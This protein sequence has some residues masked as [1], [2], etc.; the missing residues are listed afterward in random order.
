MEWP[1]EWS[2]R[3]PEWRAEVLQE[4]HQDHNARLEQRDL[5]DRG[6]P[7]DRGVVYVMELAE[8]ADSSATG[9]ATADL[10]RIG[11][12][13]DDAR[14]RL[15]VEVLRVGLRASSMSRTRITCRPARAGRQRPAELD[16]PGTAGPSAPGGRPTDASA[17]GW[18]HILRHQAEYSS[19]G[20]D[21]AFERAV[22]TLPTPGRR[23][24]SLMV[25]V[26]AVRCPASSVRH[27]LS[28]PSTPADCAGSERRPWRLRRM[29][30]W[31]SVGSV[32]TPMS[33]SG[34]RCR[35]RQTAIYGA[36]T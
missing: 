12:R 2:W 17:R 36:C 1:P 5:G 13:G 30:T 20:H 29:R 25:D 6:G 7:E 32:P 23:A 24:S 19:A 3:E 14:G 27:H 10:Q 34:C 9:R 18:H 16:V 21:T 28:A 4:H 31:W 26:H 22:L 15:S 8:A 11:V 33:P 35:R